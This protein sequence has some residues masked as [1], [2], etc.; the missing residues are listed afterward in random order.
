MLSV[1]AVQV[2]AA[3]GHEG[4]VTPVGKQLGLILLGVKMH[5]ADDQPCV[6]RVVSASSQTPVSG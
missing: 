4:E 3:V 5:T 1:D 2:L 6:S